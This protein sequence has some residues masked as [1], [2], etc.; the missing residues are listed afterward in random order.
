M[1]VDVVLGMAHG[2]EG[3]GKVTHHLLKSGEY[4]HCMRFNG[5]LQRWSHHLSQR[6]EAR[7][8]LLFQVASFTE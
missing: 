6:R 5:G 4:T 7:H 8:T 3:K 2:D 1:I